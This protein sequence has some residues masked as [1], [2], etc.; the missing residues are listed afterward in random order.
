MRVVPRRTVVGDIDR[1]FDNLS[2]SHVVCLGNKYVLIRRVNFSEDELVNKR[3][4]RLVGSTLPIKFFTVQL[5]EICALFYA[6]FVPTE[7]LQ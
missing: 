1:R 4:D 2:G 7:G 5:T 3:K 6:P